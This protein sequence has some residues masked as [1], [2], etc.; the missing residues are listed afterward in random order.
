VAISLRSHT[1][2]LSLKI[3]G[4]RSPAR[5][6]REEK[7]SHD[8]VASVLRSAKSSSSHKLVSSNVSRSRSTPARM[9]KTVVRQ[10]AADRQNF[11]GLELMACSL[12]MNDATR[13]TLSAARSK[14][15]FDRR[16]RHS[17]WSQVRIHY[18][19]LFNLSVTS[20]TDATARFME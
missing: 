18:H 19:Y 9:A 5:E 15:V 3:S 14:S 1:R 4:G 16:G 11:T 20:K 8:L 2:S 6:A 13:L 17:V 7:Q 10:L 12:Q